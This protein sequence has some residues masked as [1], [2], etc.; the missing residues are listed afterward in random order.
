MFASSRALSSLYDAALALAYPQPC[1][2]CGASVESNR[3]GVVCESCWQEATTFSNSDTLCWQCGAPLPVHI[4]REKREEVRCRCC[5]ESP[6]SAARA[7]GLYEGA[8]RATIIE[9][10]RQPHVPNH[11]VCLLA[12]TSRRAPLDRATAIVPVPLHPDR[13]RQRGFNQAAILA[14]KLSA[15]TG[16]PA[17]EHCLVRT[18][19]T[20]RHRA[21][22]DAQARQE[23]VERAFAVVSPEAIE[24]ERVLLVDDV[25][26]TGATASACA[27]VLLASGAEEV[28]VLTV[29]R[30]DRRVA[31]ASNR[32]RAR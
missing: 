2:V 14:H 6:F 12:A 25:L 21:G 7:C 9:L 10:K 16:W 23:S 32:I 13:E 11:L 30:P 24:G 5:D 29:A 27:R 22:M 31:A 18:E 19:H 8:L 26:T 4:E 28:L 20:E 15:V 1:A 17:L 3:Y